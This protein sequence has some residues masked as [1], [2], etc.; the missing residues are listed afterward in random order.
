M[1]KDFIIIIIIIIIIINP[2]VHSSLKTFF[3]M[4]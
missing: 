2:S 4:L 1:N 3:H